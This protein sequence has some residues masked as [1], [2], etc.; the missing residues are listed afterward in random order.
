MKKEVQPAKV[1]FFFGPGWKGLGLF[2]SKFW[3]YNKED[4]KKRTD[5]LENGKG[6]MSFRGARGL[7]SSITMI[8]FGT[9]FFALITASVSVVLSVAFLIAYVFI[10]LIWFTDRIHLLRKGIFVACPNC[11][12]KY[13]IPTYICP[14][15][16]A[17]HTKLTPGKYGVLYRT[18][19]CGNK[20]PTHFF[21]GR[22]R[23]DAE[24]PVCAAALKATANR[25]ICVPVIG[26][27]SSGKTAY[28]TAFS[29]DFIEKTAPENGIEIQHYDEKTEEFYKTVISKDYMGGITTM[30]KTE[31]DINQASSKAFSFIV[32]HEKVNPD[33]VIQIYD[34]AGESFVDNTEN[35]AQL[36]YSYCHG[37]VFMLDPVSIPMIRNYMDEG[38]DKSSVG[39]LDVDL[40]LDSFLNKLRQITGQ[41]STAVFN[42]PIAIV[43]SKSD[44][45][46]IDKS[47]G[48]EK[49]SEYMARN[50]LGTDSFMTAEDAVCRQF[51]C[52]N[53]LANFVNNIEMKFKNNR[54]FKCSSI[55]HTR[56][57]GEYNPRGVLE[58][59]EWIFQTA[60]NG[61]KAIWHEH[62]F[63]AT[64]RGEK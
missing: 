62:T 42:I 7:V 11:K 26:G 64:V 8:L 47:I 50:N 17:K 28:I 58:P 12:S 6:I 27:R 32:H 15:C 18:C 55:G 48:D 46:V 51:L 59:M 3:S 30:T 49:I 33:R 39:T 63:G 60:D 57:C 21:T 16:G 5:K 29:Y 35:E 31:L 40:V 4:I 43:I 20:L 52:D 19:N 1:N 10:M 2:I 38:V 56:E 34:V 44:I 41:S 13:L 61:M 45:G 14:K 53:G 22:G 37:I 25:P 9:L 23:L 54:Y 24:C 36:Q